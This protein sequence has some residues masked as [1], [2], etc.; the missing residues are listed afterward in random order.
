MKI[1]HLESGNLIVSKNSRFFFVLLGFAVFLFLAKGA[2]FWV[3]TEENVS[4]NRTLA[5]LLIVLTVLF[6]CRVWSLSSRF[7]FNSSEKVLKYRIQYPLAN[8]KGVIPTSQI[9]KAVVETDIDNESRI[10]IKCEDKEIPMSATVQR[11]EKHNVICDKINKWLRE[12]T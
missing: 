6:F 1:Q 7:E 11:S 10:I 5:A 8:K 4:G 12:N 9:Q 2:F 3:L